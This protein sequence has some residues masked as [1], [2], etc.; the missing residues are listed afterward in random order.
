MKKVILV[1]LAIFCVGCM[2]NDKLEEN[3]S[4]IKEESEITEESSEQSTEIEEIIEKVDNESYDS[5]YVIINKKHHL[6][7]DFVPEDL[8][9]VE[10][11]KN[12]DSITMRKEAAIALKEMADAAKEDGINLMAVSG[13]RSYNYQQTLF[14]NYVNRDGEEAANRYSA[15]PGESEHQT[16]WAMDLATTDEGCVLSTC[17]EDTNGGKWLYENAYKY[18]F[19][20]RYPEGKEE[21]TGYIYEPWH[22]RYLGKDEALKVFESGLTLEEYYKLLD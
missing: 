12:K 13:F 8:V 2:N 14:N 6:P 16:G 1:L 21:I 19:I 3:T 9:E 17:F 18:G 20:L 15:K 5:L 4:E 22:F 10:I 7:E 11:P